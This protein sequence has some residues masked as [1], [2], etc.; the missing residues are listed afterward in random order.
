MEI[1]PSPIPAREPANRES[2]PKVKRP[3]ANAPPRRL[4]AGAPKESPQ[5]HREPRR[6]VGVAVR[7]HKE[8][9]VPPGEVGS[10]PA[11]A[12]E[13]AREISAEGYHAGLA[14][15]LPNEEDASSKIHV[16][17]AKPG[18]LAQ[19]QAGAV[20][21]Q[22]KRSKGAGPEPRPS[23]RVDCGENGAHLGG[24]ED[25]RDEVRLGPLRR[26]F[27]PRYEA[28]RIDPAP[29]P[30]ELA[31]GSEFRR[32][33]DWLATREPGE[34]GAQ[35]LVK[36]KPAPLR[37]VCGDMSVEAPQREL[38]APIRK[39]ERALECEEAFQ[40]GSETAVEEAFQRGTGRLKARSRRRATR[41]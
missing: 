23:E 29:K 5:G 8:R 19:T 17:A 21:H 13:L 20:E 28:G 25:V 16:T 1:N 14:L 38:A 41:T 31:H 40:V 26:P 9:A 15:A 39:A 22:N 30:K 2:V 32:D 35:E 18:D 24:R 7:R 33:R 12:Q 4:E 36:P 37:C 34:P 10:R 11:V 27:A 6:S 3:R